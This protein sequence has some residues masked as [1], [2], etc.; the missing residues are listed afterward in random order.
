[1]PETSPSRCQSPIS[2]PR[3]FPSRCHI[4][5]IV[6]RPFPASRP[7]R[8]LPYIVGSSTTST[9]PFVSPIYCHIRS[10]SLLFL[11]CARQ[12]VSTRLP[13]SS[14]SPPLCRLSS[15]SRCHPVFAEICASSLSSS[16][17]NMPSYHISPTRLSHRSFVAAPLVSRACPFAVTLLLRRLPCVFTSFPPS[18]TRS[19]S[20]LP[21]PST[22][23]SRLLLFAAALGWS[24][25]CPRPFV[26]VLLPDGGALFPLCALLPWRIIVKIIIDHSSRFLAPA[27]LFYA[28]FFTLVALEHDGLNRASAVKRRKIQQKFVK[29]EKA[30]DFS[31]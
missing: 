28:L 4:L 29:T 12:S 27:M 5:L 8:F 7:S 16:V 2:L 15:A 23:R 17:I 3:G 9:C 21:P 25:T 13:I 11:R 24:H 31:I 14:T 1:M 22:R 20:C 18:P 6:N 26:P 30:G 10:L 19:P